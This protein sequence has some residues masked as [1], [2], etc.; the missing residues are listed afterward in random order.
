M[1]NF[2]KIHGVPGPGPSTRGEKTFFTSNFENARFQF[3][4]EAILE[5]QKNQWMGQV[6]RVCSLYDTYNKYIVLGPSTGSETFS[7]KNRGEELCHDKIEGQILRKN[8]SQFLEK[9][10][11][12][13]KSFSTK[14]G[15]FFFFR[16]AFKLFFD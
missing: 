7:L 11:K 13:A 12:G 6:T 10:K 5:N 14:K 3:S 8:K 2:L 1:V 15:N 16:K 4:K 9:M